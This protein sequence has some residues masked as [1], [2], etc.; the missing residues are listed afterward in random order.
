MHQ[1][2]YSIQAYHSFFISRHI[3]Y[4][5]YRKMSVKKIQK[6]ASSNSPMLSM[7]RK[8]EPS[9]APAKRK[10][11]AFT[12]HNSPRSN[13]YRRPVYPWPPYSS[14]SLYLSPEYTCTQAADTLTAPTSPT[15]YPARLA[16]MGAPPRPAQLSTSVRSWLAPSIP[17]PAVNDALSS[18][19]EV[20]G[21]AVNT[22]LGPTLY[23]TVQPLLVSSCRVSPRMVYSVPGQSV[24]GWVS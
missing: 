2:R 7:Y 19:Q 10:Q 24:R 12:Q 14:L 17:D 8:R 11:N 9:H 1:T 18:V 15:I 16:P 5:N 20:S 6:K 21:L 4:H 3:T 22:A 23:C 13:L